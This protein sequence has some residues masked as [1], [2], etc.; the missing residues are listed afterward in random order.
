MAGDGKP[1]VLVVCGGESYERRVSLES[2]D[3]VAEGLLAAGFEVVKLDTANPVHLRPGDERFLTGAVGTTPP[4]E[5]ESAR[6][7]RHGW[8]ALTA[9]L[10]AAEVDVVFPILHGGWG[11]DGRF[12]A[13]LEL[14]AFP[15][16]GSGVL[17]CQ[18]AMDKAA[19]REIAVRAGVDVADGFVV[20]ED[21]PAAEAAR[22]ALDELGGKVVLKP[23]HGGS[24]VDL[25]IL[26]DAGAC[27]GAI[28]VIREH[29]D[30]PLVERYIPGREMTVSFLDRD[31]HPVIEIDPRTGLY[32]YTRKYTKGETEYHCPAPLPEEQAREVQE[33]AARVYRALGC[34]HFGRVDWRLSPEGRWVFLEVNT[35]PGMT[36]LSLVPMAAKATGLDFPALMARYVELALRDGPRG[37]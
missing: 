34:R 1:R 18:R 11:E 10:A 15:Y 22:R 31:P 17:A 28:E 21:E 35:V 30:Q 5:V 9:T 13:L 16:L 25:F 4:E 23:R 8:V 32:D 33:K 12:Q 14:L 37:A 27:A 36:A 20:E 2:G 3:A 19:A 29:G 24:T 26:G 6:L 7:D